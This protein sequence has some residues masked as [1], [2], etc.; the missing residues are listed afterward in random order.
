MVLIAVLAAWLGGLFWF[1]AQIPERVED[2]MTRTDAIVVL[3]GGSGRLGTGFDLLSR[4]LAKKLFVSGVYRGVEV[5]ELLQITQRAAEEIGCCV[6]LGYDAEDTLG[7]AA[8][9]AAWMAENGY[10]SL[11]VVTANYHLPRGLLELRRVMP[12]VVLIAHPVFP[13]YVRLDPWWRWPGTAQLVVGEY[14]KYLAALLRGLF[15]RPGRAAG[16][17]FVKPV[18]GTGSVNPA[19]NP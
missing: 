9:T 3:T 6:I 1:Y 11:R 15:S 7:N 16:K 4:D 14:N 17:S 10:R 5:A 18:E 8:E 13:E 12:D 2:S 19:A